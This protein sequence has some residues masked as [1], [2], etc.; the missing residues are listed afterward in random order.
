[1]NL[2]NRAIFDGLQNKDAPAVAQLSLLYFILLAVSVG[3][4]ATQVRMALQ[5]RWRVWLN[6]CVVDRW[7]SH[8]HHYQLNL[9][10]GDHANPEYRIADDVRVATE[11]P[12][13][14]VSGIT[15]ALLSALTFIAVLWTL[16][17]ALDVTVGS[18][19]PGFL[20]LLRSSTPS[21]PAGRWP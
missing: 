5:R 1:M 20:S 18:I 16:G 19:N 11:A 4:S 6:D 9:V 14:F 12:V 2:W 17:G 7:I 10:R 3:L 21:S 15:R 13:D 8:G